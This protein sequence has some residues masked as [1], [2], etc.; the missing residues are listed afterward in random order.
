MLLALVH[1]ILIECGGGGL[2]AVTINGVETEEGVV[3]LPPVEP[4]IGTL[5]R[6]VISI[7]RRRERENTPGDND[8]EVRWLAERG[9]AGTTSTSKR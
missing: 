8:R 5:R 3:L 4:A 6:G 7:Y 1:S 2:D 9:V